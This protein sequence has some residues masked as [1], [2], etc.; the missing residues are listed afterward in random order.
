MSAQVRGQ[1][2]AVIIPLALF[3]AGLALV[4]IV[5]N[6]N[7]RTYGLDLGLYTK[8]L[9]DYLH[10]RGCDSSF[11]LWKPQSLLGDH[12]D[13]YLVI[14][15]PLVLLGGS[16][17]LLALQIAAIVAGAYGVYRLIG[18][19][20]SVRWL[21]VAAMLCLLLFFGV[22]H[23]AAF[24]YHSNVV[25][26]MLLPWLL[27]CFRQR[28]FGWAFALVAAM[29]A[30]KET[31]PLWLCFVLAAL[32]WD[33]RRDVAA[34]RWIGGSLLFC[35]AY[36]A[37]ATL[38]IMPSLSN[39]GSSPGFWRYS[40][41]GDS[42]GQVALWLLEHPLQALRNLF[43]NTSGDPANDGLKAEFYWCALAS[44]GLLACL[45]P[46][47]LL[48]LIPLIGQKMLSR[49]TGFWG[50]GLHYN[51]EFAPVLVIA[52]FIAI[53]QFKPRRWQIPAAVLTLLLTAGTTRFATGYARQPHTKI[54]TD[55]VQIFNRSHYGQQAFDRSRAYQMLQQ[56]PPQ[57]SACAITYFTPHIADR[58]SAYI[59]PMGLGY[60]ARYYLLKK[61]DGLYYE[62][63]E[64]KVA[65][66]IADTIHFRIVDTDGNLYLLKTR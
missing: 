55:R 3:A 25:A 28:R 47:Y 40:H 17:A 24:D 9:Y 5:N 33:Y 57:A 42:F 8:A 60:G 29:S 16:Y 10:L 20:S 41:M 49:D 2:L 43:A 34:R 26:A 15:S 52:S 22:W 58:D 39:G 54:D 19:Y 21:P 6:F 66:M 11:F 18:L 37:A 30:A 1:R 7:F 32:L 31:M 45:K 14:F 62:G 64:E 65:E 63:E 46:N 48:M 35:A 23:A 4:S 44:G 38:W 12:L 61:H 51:I 56:I 36:L 53:S 59:F 50:V 27:Y 13:L